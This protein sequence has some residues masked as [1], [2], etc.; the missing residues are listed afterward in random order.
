MSKNSDIG[1]ALLVGVAVGAGLGILLAPEKGSKTREKL[2][3]GFDEAK[4]KVKDKYETVS[5]EIKDRISNINPEQ[6]YDDIVNNLTGKSED[7]IKF[8]EE[9]LARLKQEAA[10]YQ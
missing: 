5:S 8:M 10:K 7:V 3:E 4:Q 2:K 6:A 9:K 1:I